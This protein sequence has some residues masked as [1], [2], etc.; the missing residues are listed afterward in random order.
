MKKQERN[1]CEGCIWAVKISERK[2]YCPYGKCVRN[3]TDGKERDGE[4][5]P[6]T[7]SVDS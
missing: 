3:R 6:G 7:E 1:P 2:I 4:R 5:G